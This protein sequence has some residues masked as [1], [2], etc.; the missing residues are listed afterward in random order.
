ITFDAAG[1]EIWL[2]LISGAALCI[3]PARLDRDPDKL[4]DY[5]ERQRVTIAQFVPSLLAVTPK[6]LHRLRCIFSGGERLASDLVRNIVADRNVP[7][8]NP[9]GPTE[10][11]I[12]VT[13]W[14][15]RDAGLGTSS[16]ALGRPILTTRTY[17]LDRYM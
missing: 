13:S 10:T 8:V 1:W 16:V 15:V 6:L 4:N 2:P 9:Y 14:P 3:S 17:V 11:T 7:L 12:Q 5:I